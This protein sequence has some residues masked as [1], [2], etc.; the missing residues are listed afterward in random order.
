MPYFFNFGFE[1]HW[2]SH[3]CF[4]R[5]RIQL[6]LVLTEMGTR[7]AWDETT[8][9]LPPR[10]SMA[11]GGR[12][13]TG[14]FLK[15]PYRVSNRDRCLH[16]CKGRYEYLYDKPYEDKK[17]VRV[18]GPFTVESLSP[19]R[20]QAVNEHGELIEEVDAATGNR[21]RGAQEAESDLQSDL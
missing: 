19:H 1:R 21:M 16:R 15:S 18:A 10:H 3:S 13:S 5:I 11:R 17:R 14:G 2:V 9:P 6:T 20:T 4:D 12:G 7:T 8:L